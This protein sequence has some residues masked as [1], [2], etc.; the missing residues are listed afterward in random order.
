MLILLRVS[1]TTS[2][3]CC[4]NVATTSPRS[5]SSPAAASESRPSVIACAASCLAFGK[6]L[7]VINARLFKGSSGSCKPNWALTTTFHASMR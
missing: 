7:G 5:A 3:P 2:K 6:L 4:F 1:R